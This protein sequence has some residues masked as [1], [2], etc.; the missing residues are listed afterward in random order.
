MTYLVAAGNHNQFRMWCH[1]YGFDGGCRRGEDAAVYL[2]SSEVA[3]GRVGCVIVRAG[4]W[5]KGPVA[6]CIEEIEAYARLHPVR[7]KAQ[8]TK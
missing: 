2:S 1:E 4:E 8:G 7:Q 6:D 3:R 5:W